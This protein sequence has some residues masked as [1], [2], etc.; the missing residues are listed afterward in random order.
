M[1]EWNPRKAHFRTDSAGRT[2]FHE[3]ISRKL[4]DQFENPAGISIC[5]AGCGLGF[6]SLALSSYFRQVT[7]ID[8]SPIALGIL[9]DES[10]KRGINNINIVQEDLLS[11]PAVKPDSYDTMV[12]SFFGSIDEIMHIALPRCRGRIFI[13]K[14]NDNFHRF[15]VSHTVRPFDTMAHAIADLNSLQLPYTKE[16]MSIEDGQ[17]LRSLE[18]AEEFFHIYA[19]GKDAELINRDYI[20]SLLEETGESEFPYYFQRKCVFSILTVDLSSAADL[21]L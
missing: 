6:L 2:H 21:I 18:E 5:D 11:D 13:L 9:R 12:F 1:F 15:S 19:R 17:P 20:R 16:D 14:K 8:I 10:V 4:A 7:A 3:I